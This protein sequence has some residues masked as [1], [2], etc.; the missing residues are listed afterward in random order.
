[1]TLAFR[2]AAADALAHVGRS[3]SMRSRISD[4]PRALHHRPMLTLIYTAAIIKIS[5]DPKLELPIAD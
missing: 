2:G 3:R 1:L 5:D 4:A